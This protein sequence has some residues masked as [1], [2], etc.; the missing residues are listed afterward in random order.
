MASTTSLLSTD[1][2]SSSFDPKKQDR[3]KRPP[4]QKDY[5]TALSTLQSKYGLRLAD[6][7]TTASGSPLPLSSKKPATPQNLPS[8][9][10]PAGSTPSS[11]ARLAPIPAKQQRGEKAKALS[12]PLAL[13][14]ARYRSRGSLVP[15]SPL[16]SSASSEGEG[17][18]G[19]GDGKI[20]KADAATASRPISE[21]ELFKPTY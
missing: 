21:T 1:T 7:A 2:T 11:S 14:R 5:A 13:L 8:P 17:L 18:R 10:N 15:P 19:K 12:S 20:R 4:P 3:A 9:A 16:S 6:D